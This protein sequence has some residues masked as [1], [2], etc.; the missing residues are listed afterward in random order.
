MNQEFR[1]TL[2]IC[3]KIHRQHLCLQKQFP[4]AN[5]LYFC[6]ISQHSHPSIHPSKSYQKCGQKYEKSKQNSVMQPYSHELSL[7][8]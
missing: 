8:K 6:R 3:I 7:Y 1:N 5:K 2:S 4:E